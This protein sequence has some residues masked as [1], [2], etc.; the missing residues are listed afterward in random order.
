[1][2]L[3][4]KQYAAYEIIACTFLLELVE[5]VRDKSSILGKYLGSALGSTKEDMDLLVENLEARRGMNKHQNQ[6]LMFLTGPAGS[7]KSTAAKVAQRFC[8]EFCAAV[9][10]MWHDETFFFT[11]CSG[12][13]AAL[14]RGVTIHSAAFMNGRVTD[15]AR[16]QWKNVRILVID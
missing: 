14:F 3:D 2:K 8:F 4:E 5:E 1:M 6:L 11:A 16:K 9:S 10:V 13:A 15:E 7:G 12:S